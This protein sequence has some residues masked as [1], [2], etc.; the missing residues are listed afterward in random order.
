[1]CDVITSAA[2]LKLYDGGVAMVHEKLPSALASAALFSATNALNNIRKELALLQIQYSTVLVLRM[3][4]YD[5]LY[6]P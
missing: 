2:V 5:V 6:A 3:V 4:L 1:M